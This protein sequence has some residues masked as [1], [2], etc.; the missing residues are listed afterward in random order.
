MDKRELG[1][2]GI[3][4]T[5]VGLGCWAIGGWM[6]GGSDD[7]DAVAAI[8]RAVEL[9]V[10]FID[11]A[12]V[13][14]KGHSEELVG[15]A[16]EGIRD[17]V[18]LATKCGLVW[19]RPGR[20]YF[21]DEDGAAI[22]RN[23]EPASIARECEESLRR[24]RTDVIDVYQC[25]WPDAAT[26]IADTMA[27][28]LKLREE[29]KVRA[30]GV[31]N[32]TVAQMTDCLRHGRIESDQP[33]YYMLDR[34]IEPEILPFC[35]ERKIGVIAYSPLGRGIL[36]GKVTEGREFRKNDHRARMPW[37]RPKNRSRVLGLLEAVR[38]IAENHGATLGQLAANWVV[39][40]PGVTTAIIGARNPAQVDEN[41]KAAGF[42][43][44]DTEQGEIRRL[45]DELGGPE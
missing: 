10:N 40:Q 41:V 21:V 9:G 5:T 23:L 18:V 20:D 37:Y 4:L 13:Y 8:R 33:Q 30:I 16:L 39:S 26:P 25:H 31:S 1:R 27:A 44:T 3:E 14:G 34:S 29:G 7:T 22:R 24:L 15:N 43:L 11:T 45:L 19:D 12:P 32:F 42:R 28:L 6:W 38:P 35:R 36:T 17:K 2:S